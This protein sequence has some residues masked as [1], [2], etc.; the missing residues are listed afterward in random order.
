MIHRFCTLL[1]LLESSISKQERK[2]IKNTSVSCSHVYCR[3]CPVLA[4]ACARE[5]SEHFCLAH[6]LQN[7]HSRAT[8]HRAH[9]TQQHD[10]AR[11]AFEQPQA[12][13]SFY[14]ARGPRRV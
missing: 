11:S 14:F 5:A 13:I 2:V 7:R 4:T 3:S 8:P 1:F 12:A 9:R 6:R 10:R